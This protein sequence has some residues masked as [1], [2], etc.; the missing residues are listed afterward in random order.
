MSIEKQF[1]KWISDSEDEA[2]LA[3]HIFAYLEDADSAD[4][5]DLSE[6]LAEKLFPKDEDEDEERG[7]GLA[8]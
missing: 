8:A 3:E 7:F 1:K 4:I 5:A 2:E 6:Y